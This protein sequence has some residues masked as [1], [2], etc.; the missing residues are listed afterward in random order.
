[1]QRFQAN[2]SATNQP[3]ENLRI[4]LSALVTRDQLIGIYVLNGNNTVSLRWLRIGK[5]VGDEVEVLSG[6]NDTER[7]VLRAEGKLYNGAVVMEKR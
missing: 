5:T 4:P 7:Y 1:M 2:K 6:L 3:R